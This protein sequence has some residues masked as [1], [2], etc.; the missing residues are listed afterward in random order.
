MGRAACRH[1]EAT[2]HWPREDHV[3]WSPAGSGALGSG[4]VRR[5][6]PRRPRQPRQ[7]VEQAESGVALSAWPRGECSGWSA[8]RFLISSMLD[9]SV[10]TQSM[11]G[12]FGGPP[13]FGIPC[14]RARSRRQTQCVGRAAP[15]T[16][17]KH[18]RR[19]LGRPLAAAPRC[20]ASR[21][22]VP[23]HAGRQR[24]LAGGATATV[25]A[26][27]PHETRKPHFCILSRSTGTCR[28]ICTGDPVS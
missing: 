28:G 23:C 1:R 7:A 16:V 3:W 8:S 10:D 13:R 18:P 20:L 17:V 2:R 19:P 6:A 5:G 25:R 22:T 4:D 26:P 14:A 24:S 15:S 21:R 12:R 27:Y 11:G 9:S